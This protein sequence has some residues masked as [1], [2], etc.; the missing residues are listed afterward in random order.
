MMGYT[1]VNGFLWYVTLNVV[2]IYI[3]RIWKNEF[4]HLRLQL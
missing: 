1:S 3:G 2:L 4:F